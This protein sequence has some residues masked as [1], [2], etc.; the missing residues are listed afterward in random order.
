[1]S[2]CCCDIAEYMRALWRVA[3]TAT[4]AAPSPTP[5]AA[6]SALGAPKHQW[7]RHRRTQ[8]GDEQLDRDARLQ[9]TSRVIGQQHDD[10]ETAQHRTPAQPLRRQHDDIVRDVQHPQLHHTIAHDARRAR[11]GR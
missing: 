11:T 5:V 3:A 7:Q 6:A 8:R 1:M 10:V 9:G 2:S 4:I